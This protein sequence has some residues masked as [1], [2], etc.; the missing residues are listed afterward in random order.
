MMFREE[1]V[2]L[3]AD[4][5]NGLQKI[6]NEVLGTAKVMKPYMGKGF[7]LRA[8]GNKNPE[9]AERL[10]DYMS[11]NGGKYIRPAYVIATGMALGDFAPETLDNRIEAGK[12]KD[13]Q[14]FIPAAASIQYDH[15][16]FLIHDDPEDY[17]LLRR[18]EPAYHVVH[19]LDFGINDGDYLD[20]L[21]ENVIVNANEIFGRVWS[22]E[23][24][25]RMIRARTDMQEKTVF[26][27]NYEF[28]KRDQH[29]SET[30]VK[31][32]IK[33]LEMKT[34]Y[35]T[36]TP[37]RY[38]SIISGKSDGFID[39][40][41]MPMIYA[42]I[43]FQIKDDLLNI[44]SE[45]SSSTGK[46]NLKDQKMGKDWAGDLNEGK[47]TLPLV[48][49]YERADPKDKKFIEDHISSR[50]PYMKLKDMKKRYDFNN[51]EHATELTRLL[52]VGNEKR[53]LPNS[54]KERI[55]QIEHECGAIQDSKKMM[56]DYLNRANEGIK[57][58]LGRGAATIIQMNNFAVYRNF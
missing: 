44:L 2:L 48:I 39:R 27:Q 6:P 33:I 41:K 54:V 17:S 16:R 30:S 18:G 42:T 34:G 5:M 46:A 38:G 10:G 35:T 52:F 25:Y 4:Q 22:D 49:A 14:K 36:E 3:Y 45:K 53:N 31:D 51:P 26:G 57:V 29:I 8:M 47:R 7:L 43:A 12:N 21:S 20:V 56:F 28:T 55:I 1:Q 37:V 40:I 23:T 32:V 15:N 58:V 9:V 24:R 19:G 50:G 11:K 13:F